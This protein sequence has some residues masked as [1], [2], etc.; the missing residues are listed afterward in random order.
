M[1]PEEKLKTKTLPKIEFESELQ[2]KLRDVFG[3]DIVFHI[4]N[5]EKSAVDLKPFGYSLIDHKTGSVYKGSDILK[6]N[7]LFEFTAETIDKNF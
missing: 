7:E 2:K 5:K 3:V 4:S 6:M 1:L